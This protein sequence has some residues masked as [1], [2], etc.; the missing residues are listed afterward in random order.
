M[1]LINNNSISYFHERK[2]K[3]LAGESN[4]HYKMLRNYS[5]YR[6]IPELVKAYNISTK[7]IYEIIQA[8]KWNERIA[9]FESNTAKAYIKE[10]FADFYNLN[11]FRRDNL[12]RL[13][14]D[15][16]HQIY[17]FQEY[18][19]VDP[20][21]LK[22]LGKPTQTEMVN[23]VRQTTRAMLD[24][25]KLVKIINEQLKIFGIDLTP[26]FINKFEQEEILGE[27]LLDYDDDKEDI[28]SHNRNEP[29]DYSQHL[30][31]QDEENPS[32]IIPQESTTA[33]SVVEPDETHENI[34]R[35][36][37]VSVVEPDETP[38]TPINKLSSAG[39]G[40]CE[41]DGGGFPDEDEETDYFDDEDDEEY[42]DELAPENYRYPFPVE[43]L[44]PVNER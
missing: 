13:A 38:E 16:Q 2:I 41:T 42:Y 4:E 36:N 43:Y 40:G 6:N 31:L 18:I 1:C 26:E 24:M 27:N 21:E 37:Q 10:H 28:I 17:N 34:E 19:T 44:I 11:N 33:I 15:T 22:C 7:E 39:G 23:V 25:Q 9:K 12:V 14:K 32:E 8:N 35:P 3:Q 30:N 5:V 29:Y 20:K